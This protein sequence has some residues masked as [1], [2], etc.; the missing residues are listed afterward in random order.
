MTTK[1]VRLLGRGLL[2]LVASVALAQASAQV[3]LYEHNDFEGGRLE[4]RGQA[5]E[6]ASRGFNDRASSVVVQSGRWQLCENNDFEGRCIT[7][8]PGEYRTLQAIGM[9]DKVSS[10]R[11]DR[12]GNANR[13]RDGRDGR[14]DRGRGRGDGDRGRG[15]G[16]P[17]EVMMNNNG[18]GRVEFA[19]R[20][21]VSYDREG[22]RTQIRPEC[23]GGQ[24][25]MANDAMRRYRREQGMGR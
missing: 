1:S 21:V 20:C 8:G 5:T 22:R 2:A 13:D 6:L 16:P 15:D 23:R 10:V 3:V 24:I 12:G 25:D 11:M 17:P 7:V 19:N 4:I 9:N 18:M 14:D